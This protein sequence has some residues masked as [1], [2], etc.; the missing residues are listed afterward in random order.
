MRV[1]TLI[2]GIWKQRTTISLTSEEKSL[3]QNFEEIK[4]QDKKALALKIKNNSL[5]NPSAN[6]SVSAQAIYNSN[7]ITG[8]TLISVEIFLPSGNGII[9]CKVNKQHRQIKF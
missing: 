4:K 8:A 2:N 7:K 1:L 6:D 5:V 9:N 3:R